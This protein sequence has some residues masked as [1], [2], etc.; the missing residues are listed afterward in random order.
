[1]C[2]HTTVVRRAARLSP[3]P[4]PDHV[5]LRGCMHILQSSGSALPHQISAKLLPGPSLAQIS[6]LP[7]PLYPEWVPTPHCQTMYLPSMPGCTCS[8]PLPTPHSAFLH[9]LSSC[10]SDLPTTYGASWVLPSSWS[11]PSVPTWPTA[12]HGSFEVGNSIFLPVDQLTL[13]YCLPK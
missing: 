13:G 11:W 1:M 3:H 8:P 5:Q 6:P 7:F 9:Y 2:T 4:P 10:L 12:I